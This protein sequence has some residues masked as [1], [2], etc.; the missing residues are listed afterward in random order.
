LA[1]DVDHLLPAIKRY[2]PQGVTIYSLDDVR[3]DDLANRKIPYLTLLN[4]VTN[5]AFFRDQDGKHTRLVTANYWHRYGGKNVTISCSLF[6]EEGALLAEWQFPLADSEESIIIDSQDVRKKFGLGP[7]V[8]QLFIHVLGAQGHDVIKYALDIYGDD[9]RHLSCTHD[10]NSWPSDSYGGLPA[11]QENE[12]VYFW[13]QNNH[14]VSIPAR[15]IGLNIM[16]EKNIV[17][18]DKK[19]LPFAS[20][21]L[22]VT[23]L[24]PQARWPQ[25]IEIQ[26]GKH[27]VRPRYEVICRKTSR[28]RIA[29][30]NVQ[31]NDLT[32]DINISKL[33]PYLGKAYILPMPIL[34]QSDFQSVAL[35]TPMATCQKQL[36]LKVFIYDAS[37]QKIA[38]ES[39]GVLNRSHSTTINCNRWSL[40]SQ[41]GHMELAYDPDLDILVDG[42]LHALVRYRKGD[43]IAETSF[44]AHIFNAPLV[45]R[46]EPQ[47]YAGNPPGLRTRL[48]LRISDGDHDSTCFLIYPSSTE[49]H[50]QSETSFILYNKKGHEVATHVINIPCHGSYLFSY[51]QA[52]PKSIR[53][54]AKDG[55][56]MIRDVTCRLF[57]YHGT[58]GKN[59]FSF[60]HMF[61]F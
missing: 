4:F 61:G 13:I 46:N 27:I 2:L 24:L 32:P 34:P 58:F 31:R 56:I 3:L 57:G 19:V 6:G 40:P 30:V 8:G 51:H 59:A 35:P 23:D 53:E 50:P 52:F 36:P 16:G 29:H 10:A 5:F 26:A 9:D 43:Q 15:A 44:G 48:F 49:W 25:Q 55:Y 1:F 33:K 41:Y 20:Y 54:Q 39:L 17:W 12:D 18:L 38:E 45:Y 7:F 22:S 42:W 37:G 28:Q 21:C 11:P 47:N 60:D 14:P